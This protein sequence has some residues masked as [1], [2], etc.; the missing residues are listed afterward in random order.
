VLKSATG[1]SIAVGDAD[2]FLRP[3]GRAAGLGVAVVTIVRDA[4]KGDSAYLGERS[5][6]VGTYPH[7]LHIIPAGNCGAQG[8]EFDIVDGGGPPPWYLRTKMESEFLEEWFNDDDLER[9]VIQDWAGYV[10]EQWSIREVEAEPMV[11]T[12]LS[13]D[14]LNLRPEIC[15]TVTTTLETLRHTKPNYEWALGAPPR[16]RSLKAVGEIAPTEIVQSAAAA[17]S[18]ARAVQPTV[19]ATGSDP[20]G[21][22]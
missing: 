2:I 12:G 19:N 13:F 1:A 5:T 14:L 20:G 21:T 6:R 9:G 17:L 15:A 18:L 8:T 4:D 11:L 16:A 22:S 3:S 7:A 10:A